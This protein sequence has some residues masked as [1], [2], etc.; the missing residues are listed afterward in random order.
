MIKQ[1]DNEKEISFLSR[2]AEDDELSIVGSFDTH[3]IC[4]KQNFF[5]EK[6]QVY[7]DRLVAQ[8]FDVKRSVFPPTGIKTNARFEE[9]RNVFRKK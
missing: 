8:G 1:T 4:S 7:M 6:I 2:L 5:V 3:D 9:V